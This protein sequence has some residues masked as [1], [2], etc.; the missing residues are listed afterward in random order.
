MAEGSA[1][2]GRVNVEAGSVREAGIFPGK[3]ATRPVNAAGDFWNLKRGGRIQRVCAVS[4][5]I[6]DPIPAML[7]RMARKVQCEVESRA[8]QAR[9]NVEAQVYRR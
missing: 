3:R 5:D 4:K 9:P 7:I 2:T 1:G 6:P 8:L